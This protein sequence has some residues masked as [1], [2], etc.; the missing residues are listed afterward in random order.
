[1]SLLAENLV[2][3]WMNRQGF[4]TIRGIRDGVAEMDL[5]GVRTK[6]GLTEGWHV[7]SQVSFNAISYVTPLTNERSKMMG[8]A[9]TTAW[10]RTPEILAES[11]AAWV[12]KKFDSK[13]KCKV[14]NRFWPGLEWR[15]K[16]V[17]G[18][19]KYPDEIAELEK[20][21]ALIPFYEVLRDLC[22]QRHDLFGATGTDIANI[23]EYYEDCAA[24]RQ[25]GA[26]AT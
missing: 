17:Y 23:V 19:A 18:C 7:E 15:K 5:L 22:W 1:M 4:F 13:A 16:L 12:E 6:N 25:R 11:V 8:K 20:R 10:K 24:V 26:L 21:I 3:E 14:R 9:K 2:E